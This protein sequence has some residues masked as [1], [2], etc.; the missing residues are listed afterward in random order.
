MN[1]KTEEPLLLNIQ[2][3]SAFLAVKP[4]TIR[5][6]AKSGK[7]KGLKVGTRGDW[8]FTKDELAKMIVID[9]EKYTEIKKFLRQHA[10]A[11]REI[12]KQKHIVHLGTENVRVV[13]LDENKDEEIKIIKELAANLEN[14]NKGTL[15]FERV[16]EKIAK[17][18]VEKQL[19]LEEAV[20]GTIFL[21]QAFWE[22]LHEEGFLHK[23]TVQDFYSFSHIITTY[24]DIV[25]SKIAF[26]FHEL[27]N[28]GEEKYQNLFNI[29]DEGFC[30][31]EVL[32]NKKGD[33][34]DYRFLETN[35]IF[36]QQ[37]GLKDV[38]GKRMKKL[39]PTH[40]KSWFE[41]YGRVA[42]TGDSI[43][44]EN[45]ATAMGRWFDVYATKVGEKHSHRVALLFKDITKRKTIEE[46][47]QNNKSQLEAVIQSIKDGIVITD[48]EGNFLFTNKAQATINKFKSIEQMHKKFIEYKNLYSFWDMDGRPVPFKEWPLTKILRGESVMN[49]VLRARRNDIAQEWYFSF[50]G[51]PIKDE[52]GAIRM[53]VV[54]TRDITDQVML[55]NQKD[56]FIGIASHELK[57]PVTSLQTYTQ[58]LERR[59]HGSED[60]KNT[61]LLTHINQ[62]AD[63]LSQLI[64][65]LLNVNKIQSGKLD[66]QKERINLDKLITKVTVDYQYMLNTH[67][68]IKKGE[69]TQ[70]INADPI[71]IE[72]ILV[73]LISNAVKYSPNADKVIV[74]VKSD[75]KDVTVCIKDFGMG[76]AKKDQEKIFERF[77][78]TA[79]SEK[80]KVKGFGLGLYISAE[81]IKQHGGKIWVESS[82]GNGSTFYFTLPYS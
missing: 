55:E 39:A 56:A 14:L 82:K 20:D 22:R 41:I 9:K 26:A 45:Y 50:S 13:K 67:Q 33:P 46:E 81:I 53:G 23:L 4:N 57:T 68:L 64:D 52:S 15:M 30:I 8:R 31:I 60:A 80:T 79:A 61:Y 76:I 25:A 35:K 62:Q 51:E 74:E 72:Q 71:K 16:G 21:K 49:W 27:Y 3:A 10:E 58:I 63:R 54:V 29:I 78:R 17:K 43:R 12:A 19:T 24:T 1:S 18:S 6:W 5:L 66:L 7:L 37:T 73:N 47:L 34:I 11:I 77:Y 40:E 42:K 75:K 28:I 65:D 70:K 38:I 32:F 44:F 2:Q 59:L 69:I 36:E 48:E